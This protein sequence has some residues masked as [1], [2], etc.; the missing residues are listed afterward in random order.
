MSSVPSAISERNWRLAPDF[1]A[2]N[3][4]IITTSVAIL[5]S[6]LFNIPNPG[7][8]LLLAVVHAVFTGGILFGLASATLATVYSS[9]YFSLPGQLFHYTDEDFRRVLAT[10]LSCYLGSSLVAWLR[11]RDEA[12]IRLEAKQAE[13]ANRLERS[14]ELFRQTMDGAPVF[15]WLADTEGH[16]YFANRPWL[17]FTGLATVEQVADGWLDLV[18]PEDRDRVRERYSNA[19]K[20][21]ESFQAEYRLR[22]FDGEYRWIQDAALPRLEPQGTLLGYIGCCFDKTER[23]RVE[24]SLHQLSGRLLELQDDER[25]R[26]ARELHDTTAQHLAVLSMNLSVVRESCKVLSSRAQQAVA[27]SMELSEQCCQEVRTVSYL[28]HPP[29]LD[30]LGL[31]SAI[32]SFTAGYERRTGIHVDIRV[33]EIGRLPRDVETTLFRIMQE[34]LTNVHRHSGSSRAEVRIIRDP[35]QVTLQ[36]SDEG[37]GVSERNGEEPKDG[38]APLGVGIAGMRERAA[39]L[40]GN[41]KIAS[42]SK[43]TTVTAVLPLREGA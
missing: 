36:V 12:G 18:H 11:R 27:E 23:K 39:Q 29:L 5:L 9:I 21:M 15:I 28:L 37:R 17:A 35:R 34:A 7:I 19:V 3:G 14:E 16:R 1:W 43:G 31:V 42:S 32:R 6:F 24:T 20:T 4:W 41:L 8:L 38:I 22:R 2:D 13:A 25:R 33:A 30:E 40:G 10:S 26:I